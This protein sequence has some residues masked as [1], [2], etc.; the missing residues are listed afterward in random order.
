MDSLLAY[1]HGHQEVRI[2]FCEIQNIQKNA[3]RKQRENAQHSVSWQYLGEK[4][5]RRWRPH[6]VENTQSAATL[7]PG[8]GPKMDFLLFYSAWPCRGHF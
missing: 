5:S 3:K 2:S 4:R 6:R 7:P 8:R 1:L